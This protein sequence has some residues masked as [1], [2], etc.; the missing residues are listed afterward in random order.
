[1]QSVNAQEKKAF[2]RS[3]MSKSEPTEWYPVPIVK[4]KWYS[5]GWLRDLG[6]PST[7]YRFTEAGIELCRKVYL[8]KVEE[9]LAKHDG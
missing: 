7:K 3:A 2:Q 5:F 4:P 8:R 1:M 9:H 6:I